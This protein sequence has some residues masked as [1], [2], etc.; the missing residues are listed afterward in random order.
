MYRLLFKLGKHSSVVLTIT[1]LLATSGLVQAQTAPETA[2]E[3]SKTADIRRTDVAYKTLQELQAKYDCVPGNGALFN[4][5][6]ATVSRAEFAAGVTSCVQ[7]IEELVAKR[8]RKPARK[9]GIKPPVEAA[10]EVA[11][12]PV[13][14]VISP[15]PTPEVVPAPPVP[16][17]APAPVE[18]L[19]ASEPA[20]TQQDLDRVRALTNGLGEDLQAL[21]EKIKKNSFST[22]TKLVGEG[23]INF[24]GYGGVPATPT[25]L[26]S[27]NFFTNRLRLN[28]DTSFAGKDRLR[29]RLQF[30]DT[31]N[32]ATATGTGMT[33][34]G[35]DGNDVTDNNGVLSLFQYDFSLGDQTRI[36]VATTGY[37]F[38][39]NQPTL[40][41]Q[42]SS[43][44]NGAISRFGR[45]NPIFRLSGD[46]A[47]VNLSQ[48]LGSEL[49]FDIGYAVPV[50]N[51]TAN[52]TP[53]N[54]FF[55]GQNA[56]LSQ[57]TYAP[58]KEFSVAALY[59]RSYS[60]AGGLSGGTGSAAANN[61]FNP[62]ALASSYLP[63][64]GTAP[65]NSVLSAAGG[66]GT[67]TAN[68]YSFLAT[69]KLGDSS[70]SPIISGW[71]GF[72]DAA[73]T[74]GGGTASISNYAVNLA[75]PDFGAS[76]NM[77]GFIVGMPPK[78]TAR[79]VTVGGVRST[80]TG[81]PDTSLH[82]EALYKI[83]L[84]DNMDV[85]PGLL[86]IT[87]PEHNSGN[88]TEYVGTMRTTFRF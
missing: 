76:G 7:S 81:N 77:L 69:Y 8:P 55:K 79:N 59:G 82:L 14:Q 47:A 2:S 30:R 75:F 32:L 86:V 23:I 3:E 74:T 58:S 71:A 53:S 11:P 44:A 39:D 6:K 63:T 52:V 35:F 27:N 72:V 37:E 20:V 18:S 73:Q 15:P 42:L 17:P 16:V 48:K 24:G 80:S 26:D 61:P 5:K 65:A 41:P 67:Y 84:N 31:T 85:T 78:L 10:P 88:P 45:F 19:E 12:E 68:H 29:S 1:F 36:R 4:G 13:P 49:S 60:N 40:N 54:G 51:A 56:V 25:R 38:N 87:N 70:D 28:F 57:L 22:T 62:T 21:D 9:R 64:T 46:G 34:L 66:N 43:G 50:A 83:K 33:R